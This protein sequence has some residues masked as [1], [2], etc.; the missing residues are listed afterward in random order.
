[1]VP[2]L[3]I[4]SILLNFVFLSFF[5]W[6][7]YNASVSA[8]LPV[9][10]S[11]IRVSPPANGPPHAGKTI[12][13]DFVTYTYR[14]PVP[15]PS[16]LFAIASGDLRYRAFDKVEGRNWNSG[17]W[18]EPSLLEGVF[19]EFKEDTTKLVEF[20]K[21]RMYFSDL[22]FSCFVFGARRFLAAE[23]DTIGEYRF[24][25]YDVLVLPPSFP[26]G[27]ELSAIE[28]LS[29]LFLCLCWTWRL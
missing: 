2:T 6:Q 4:Y 27:G 25:T 10:L 28:I 9:L 1:M 23:E 17:V 3:N 29:A 19:W 24:G 16:Y 18:T 20:L 14:Q 21:L 7:T 5:L 8:V 15:I 22:I 26:Y 11:A 12:G 13:K